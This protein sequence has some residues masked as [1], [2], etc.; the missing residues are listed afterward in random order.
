MA[1]YILLTILLTGLLFTPASLQAGDVDDL[2][3]AFDHWV[4]AYNSRSVEDLVACYH[5]QAVSFG[6]FKE[7]PVVEKAAIR[8][9]VQSFYHQVEHVNFSPND[10]QFRVIDNTG[11][12]WSLYSLYWRG[13]SA[14]RMMNT[15]GR[16]TLTF[17]KTDGKW[18]IVSQHA[19]SAVID[20]DRI[21]MEHAREESRKVPPGTV[22][23]E[24][25]ER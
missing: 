9:G 6:Q 10:P 16:L 7:P 19:S 1:K 12:V 5:D 17:V 4:N 13:R 20:T 18:L 8:E 21:K 2:K 25:R 14:I 15:F 3:V 24:E 23:E 22:P 11:V